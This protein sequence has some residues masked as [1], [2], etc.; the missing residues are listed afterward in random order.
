MFLSDSEIC[1]ISPAG[2]K[3]YATP[4]QRYKR[5]LDKA[6]PGAHDRSRSP[7]RFDPPAGPI[8]LDE[9]Y[10]AEMVKSM[11]GMAKA[12]AELDKRNQTLEQE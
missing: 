1:P 9:A 8:R 7:T 6:S 3:G 12:I 5:R 4:A 2:T 10:I 11:N